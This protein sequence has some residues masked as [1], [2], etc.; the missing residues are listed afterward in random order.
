MIWKDITT[1]KNLYKVSNTGLVKS[2]P[3]KRTLKSGLTK[4]KYLTV[5]LCDSGTQKSYYVHRLV[6]E[7][8]VPNPL[9]KPCVNHKDGDKTNNHYRNLEW[10]TYQEN[11][12]HYFTY[13][14]NKMEK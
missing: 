7:Q 3:H 6:A 11:T 1:Y 14:K 8:F 9:H 13:L 10:V 4:N 2:I 12:K 5:G